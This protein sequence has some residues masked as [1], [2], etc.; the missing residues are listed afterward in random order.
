MDLCKRCQALD[1]QRERKKER[2]SK[3]VEMLSQSVR[4]WTLWHQQSNSKNCEAIKK[5]V[6][7]KE[8]AL[9]RAHDRYWVLDL[10]P[11][12]CGVTEMVDGPSDFQDELGPKPKCKSCKAKLQ[13]QEDEREKLLFDMYKLNSEIGDL[14]Q[15]YIKNGGDDSLR[16]KLKQKSKL[17]A[18]VQDKYWVC[19]DSQQDKQSDSS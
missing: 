7:R 16:L 15:E 13:G 9:S 2:V 14:H 12:L 18:E 17:L 3:Y 4:K 6:E 8:N 10:R 11:Q 5:I 1:V 19:D